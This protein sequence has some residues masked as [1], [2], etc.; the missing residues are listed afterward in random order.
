M[1]HSLLI[2]NVTR[3]GAEVGVGGS[4]KALSPHL[5]LLHQIGSNI[6]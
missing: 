6:H 4:P 2:H 5:L 1:K 3:I